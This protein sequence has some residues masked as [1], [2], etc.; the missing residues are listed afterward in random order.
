M[1]IR[2]STCSVLNLCIALFLNLTGCNASAD[3][4]IDSSGIVYANDKLWVVGD[5]SDKKR[6]ELPLDEIN[7]LGYIRIPNSFEHAKVPGEE[8]ESIAFAGG[9]FFTLDEDH[10]TVFSSNFEGIGLAW[11]LKDCKQRNNKGLEGLSVRQDANEPGLYHLALTF[12]GYI[13]G[14]DSNPPKVLIRSIKSSGNKKNPKVENSKD[15]T[16]PDS[17]V[18]I[19][20]LNN[21]KKDRYC[22]YSN[23]RVVEVVWYKAKTEEGH[24][25]WR[26]ITLISVGFEELYDRCVLLSMKPDGTDMRYFDIGKVLRDSRAE[27]ETKKLVAE[28][29]WEGMTLL[30]ST[31]IGDPSKEKILLIADQGIE[32]EEGKELVKHLHL[33]VAEIENPNQ[34]NKLN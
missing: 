7:K 19:E 27:T 20:A 3:P 2:N 14:N 8:L 22:R 30:P 12:E 23:I 32:E 31:A 21:K 9:N 18:K 29:N 15:I 6:F 28:L 5:E 10:H 13:S 11:P 16:I 26:L 34:W 17:I 1:N 33:F 4:V 25:S 24:P